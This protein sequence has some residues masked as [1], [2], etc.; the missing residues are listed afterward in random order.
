[1]YMF[2][3]C[4]FSI[5]L[6]NQNFTPNDLYGDIMMHTSYLEVVPTLVYEPIPM[7]IPMA[8]NPEKEDISEEEDPPKGIDDPITN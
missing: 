7:Y 8:M 2:F 1:M 5:S 6:L 3:C 4:H